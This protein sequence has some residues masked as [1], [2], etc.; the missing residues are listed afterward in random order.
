MSTSLNLLWS[1]MNSLQLIV[2]FPLLNLRFPPHVE[3][4][5]GL[6][7]DAANFKV[8]KVNYLS[9]SIFDFSKSK[10]LVPRH[11]RFRDYS[12]SSSNFILNSELLI[13]VFYIY[14]LLCLPVYFSH[15][16]SKGKWMR[17]FFHFMYSQMFYN[18]MIR[19]LIESCMD[20]YLNAILNIF[21]MFFGDFGGKISSVLSVL[22]FS[23]YSCSPLLLHYW[24]RS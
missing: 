24:L 22:F 14:I 20:L 6:L 12:H 3:F 5:S 9:T 1:F 23:F 13:W 10:N 15:K 11:A 2:S 21:D 7:N 4:V 17:K 18:F 16:F 8:L 19:F